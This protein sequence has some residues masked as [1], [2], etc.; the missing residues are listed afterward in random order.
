MPYSKGRDKAK[1]EAGFHQ[2]TQSK[3]RTEMKWK[4]Q[5][6][7]HI[8]VLYAHQFRTLSNNCSPCR[9]KDLTK[10]QKGTKIVAKTE[11]LRQYI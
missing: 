8:T 1:K 7:V 2:F 3:G 6:E 10:V 9:H 5:L 11:A 4:N